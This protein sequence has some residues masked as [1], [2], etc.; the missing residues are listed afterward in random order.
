MSS[1]SAVV[2]Q[3][4]IS[5]EPISLDIHII[6]KNILHFD[7]ES[8]TV[9]RSLRSVSALILLITDFQQALECPCQN[10]R[11][12]PCCWDC[13]VRE[14]GRWMKS[15]LSLGMRSQV[16]PFR[17][18]GSDTYISKDM[19]LFK[20]VYLSSERGEIVHQKVVGYSL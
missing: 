19:M 6:L 2:H 18:I 4:Q 1:E 20:F 11:C 14:V 9:A 15:L 7:R 16:G 8:G 12:F 13:P 5:Q 17:V 3:R 10:A